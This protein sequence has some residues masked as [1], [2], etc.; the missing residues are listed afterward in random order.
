MSHEVTTRKVTFAEREM[1]TELDPRTLLF[2]S[3]QLSISLPT[4]R[5][6]NLL[7]QRTNVVFAQEGFIPCSFSPSALKWFAKRDFVF[8][9]KVAKIRCKSRKGEKH[10]GFL[11]EFIFNLTRENNCMRREKAM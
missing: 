11:L 4:P 7:M 8:P 10:D 2:L 5:C 9:I 1:E 6:K 3:F